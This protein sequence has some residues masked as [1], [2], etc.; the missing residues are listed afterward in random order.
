MSMSNPRFSV[1]VPI[2]NS[3]TYLDNC[4]TSV[5]TQSFD[6]C[7]ILLIN[8]GSTDRSPELVNGYAAANPDRVRCMHKSNEGLLMTRLR[9][10]E[11]AQGDYVLNLDS[12]D[13]L[14]PDALET[15]SQLIDEYAPDLI[16]FQASVTED[17]ETIWKNCALDVEAGKLLEPEKLK[18]IIC[19]GPQI[20]NMA[21]KCV[22][23]GLLDGIQSLARYRFMNNEED[24]V[25]SAYIIDRCE[26]PLYLQENLYFYRQ[27]NSGSISNNFNPNIFD[28]IS[29]S[30]KLV[31]EYAKLWDVGDRALPGAAYSRNLKACA[32]MIRYYFERTDERD[33]ILDFLKELQEDEFFREAYEN[34]ASDGLTAFEKVNVKNLYNRKIGRV[35][36]MMGARK[37]I[38]KLF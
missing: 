8:D 16:L 27:D 12:D 29:S 21:L 38:K 34:G 33:V 30:G 23:R 14:R 7:E 32:S 20:N 5:L 37:W 19:K 13:Q 36:V 6:D 25:Q 4:V 2:Y 17:Y 11:M 9:G 35:S 22:R 1:I 28:S 24:L 15:L 31:L 3:E 18:R 26:R 10:Y